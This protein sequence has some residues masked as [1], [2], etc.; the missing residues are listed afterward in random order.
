MAHRVV[1]RHCLMAGLC[2]EA[3]GTEELT[4]SSSA[5][6]NDER[7]RLGGARHRCPYGTPALKSSE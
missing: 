4:G 5:R 7:I 3:E 6:E 2:S 1:L